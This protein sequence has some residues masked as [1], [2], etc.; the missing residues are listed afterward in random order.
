MKF[1]MKTKQKIQ[2]FGLLLS[3]TSV[4]LAWS[5]FGWKMVLVLILAI[6]GNNIEQKFKD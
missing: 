2:L 4:F 3:L 5:W 6:T 1:I